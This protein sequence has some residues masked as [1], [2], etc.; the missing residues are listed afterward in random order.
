[1]VRKGFD[2]DIYGKAI[3][4]RCLSGTGARGLAKTESGNITTPGNFNGD[5]EIVIMLAV[6]CL[7]VTPQ[8]THLDTD[9]G[10]GPRIEGRIPGEN[11][12]CQL[13][14]GQRGCFTLEGSLNQVGE[15]FPESS[16]GP[17]IMVVADSGAVPPDQFPVAI[18][19][20][21]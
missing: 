16:R 14:L 12:A 17:K 8:F 13:A 18:T 11:I 20:H 5:R 7:K 1:M 4:A 2:V 6:E 9:Y 10:V 21:G 3:S 15:R 19:E